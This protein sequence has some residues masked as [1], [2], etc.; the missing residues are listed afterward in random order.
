MWRNKTAISL[1]HNLTSVCNLQSPSL[2]IYETALWGSLHVAL[3]F[4]G[5]RWEGNIYISVMYISFVS[6][7]GKFIERNDLS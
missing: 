3:L 4:N 1:P 5:D 6:L 7:S 2:L